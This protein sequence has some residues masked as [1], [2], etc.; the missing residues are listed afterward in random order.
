MKLSQIDDEGLRLERRR[1]SVWLARR[2]EGAMAQVATHVIAGQTEESVERFWEEFTASPTFGCFERL[3][4]CA[5]SSGQWPQ[6]R[7]RVLEY[8]RQCTIED[9]LSLK[10]AAIWV[11][12]NPVEAL[13][14]Y[15]RLIRKLLSHKDRYSAGQAR[16][17]L[18]KTCR[19][20]KRLGHEEEYEEFIEEL[21][22]AFGSQRNFAY[23]IASERSR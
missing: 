12:A 18:R 3:K 4:E 8:S 19:L 15:Q 1:Q 7:E 10:M 21:M 20:M 16:R 22:Q 13:V 5:L 14:I 6:W 17:L 23:A 9:D 11:R 2:V